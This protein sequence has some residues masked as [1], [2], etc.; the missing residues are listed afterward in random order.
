[1]LTPEALSMVQHIF[2]SQ[3]FVWMI[4]F[5]ALGLLGLMTAILIFHWN[6][7]SISTKVPKFVVSVYLCVSLIILVLMA[8]IAL[9][10]LAP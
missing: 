1:M 9:S 3:T 7:Y 10:Y 5:V 6:R 4:F 8:V 2:S